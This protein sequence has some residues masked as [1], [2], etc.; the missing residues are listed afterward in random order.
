MLIV[1]RGFGSVD[2]GVGVD[3]VQEADGSYST[4][5]KGGALNR[6]PWEKALR[7]RTRLQQ[8][9]GN[10]YPE[11][12]RSGPTLVGRPAG[13]RAR[14]LLELAKHGAEPQ[15]EAQASIA[16]L[17]NWF[18]QGNDV[19]LATK[20]EIAARQE[21]VASLATR[22]LQADIKG[23]NIDTLVRSHV[24]GTLA[25]ARSMMSRRTGIV[26]KRGR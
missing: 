21:V 4:T 16:E 12:V 14:M 7:E 8:L 3:T 1:N 24:D 11:P 26:A 17:L 18:R 20:Q 13:M 25:V 6:Y 22:P 15:Q 10:S 5:V 9:R 19:E 2:D 23:Q